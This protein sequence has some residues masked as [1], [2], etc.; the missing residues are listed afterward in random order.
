MKR[1]VAASLAALL[2]VPLACGSPTS[3]SEGG[4]DFNWTVDGAAFR[5]SSNGTAALRASG[6]ISLTGVDCGRGAGMS[7]MV[8]GEPAV[9]ALTKDRF[10][11]NW[12]PDARTGAAASTAWE[13]SGSRGGGTLTIT[14]ISSSRIAGT[15]AL[16]MAPFGGAASGNRAVSGAFDLPFADRRVC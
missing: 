2:L 1:S 5:A 10:N 15:F 3:P 7:L 11:A 4:A 14:A 16:D 13:V 6:N 8:V 12:T 9:G